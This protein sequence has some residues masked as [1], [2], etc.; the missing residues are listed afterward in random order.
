MS[1]PWEPSPEVV[2]KNRARRPDFGWTE[3]DV[4]QFDLPSVL[5][6]DTNESNWGE[7]RSDIVALLQ[8]EMFG[9]V[10]AGL[11]TE[12]SISEAT[13]SR[14]LPAMHR[15]ITI[16]ARH[17]DQSVT[18]TS[19]VFVPSERTGPVPAF[20]LI[21][22]REQT[23]DTPLEGGESEGFWPVVDLVQ[24]GYATAA[25]HCDPVAPDRMDAHD[26]GV[27]S[28]IEDLGPHG[29]STLAAWA[30][31]AGRVLDGLQEI[32]EVDATRVGVI[33]HSRGG[34][35]ALWAA[36][37][38]ERFALAVSNESG[39]GGAA[40]SRRRIGETVRRINTTFPY[41]FNDQFKTYNDREN[42]LPFDQHFV[43][44]AIAPRAVY[45]GSADEDLWADPGGEYASLT[46]AN[47]VFALFG[48]EPLPQEMPGLG[49]QRIAGRR[50]YHVRPGRH[51]L[52]RDDWLLVLDF[53]DQHL[54]K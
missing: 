42:D 20:V 21:D 29:W 31:A 40:L 45:V 43:I 25:F 26:E 11:T 22:H 28:L 52:T 12:I 9:I 37:S 18:F 38:D 36:A 13:A 41:W 15:V 17:R 44:S 50:G 48:D 6:S 32:K 54:K 5:T 46:A 3:T 10:P 19:N 47:K 39:C 16:T 4:P 23:D 30:W 35:T 27:H 51:N 7:R 49:E 8:R 53:A 14:D 34:K 24:R 2:A 33:G 1:G